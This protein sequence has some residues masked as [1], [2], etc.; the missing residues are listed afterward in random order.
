MRLA[1]IPAAC[2]ELRKCVRLCIHIRMC[3]NITRPTLLLHPFI[4]KQN[5]SEQTALILMKNI[6]YILPPHFFYTL[7]HPL[8]IFSA[9]FLRV[10]TKTTKFHAFS[11]WLNQK[12]KA[13][14]KKGIYILWARAKLSNFHV[15]RPGRRKKFQNEGLAIHYMRIFLSFFWK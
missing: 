10:S 3:I 12:K 14:E 13:K 7:H 2:T 1:K 4:T 5:N 11:N 15:P 9:G 8:P 6:A